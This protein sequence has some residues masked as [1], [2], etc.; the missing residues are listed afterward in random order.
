[1]LNVHLIYKP[2]SFGGGTVS[3]RGIPESV[4]LFEKVQGPGSPQQGPP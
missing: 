4:Q 3:V 1:M 2:P